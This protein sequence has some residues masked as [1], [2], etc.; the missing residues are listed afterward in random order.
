MRSRRWWLRVLGWVCGGCLTML[1]RELPLACGG[2]DPPDLGTRRQGVDWPCFLGMNHD[3]K[4]PERGIRTR[5]PAKGLPP[6]WVRRLGTS[7]GMPTISRGRLYSFERHGDQAELHCLQSETGAPLW[8]YAY[9]TEFEDPYGYDN[10]PR[11]SPTVDGEHV[12]LFGAEGML[13]CL[14]CVDG[15]L[16]WKLDTAREFGVVP[17]FFGVGSSPVVEGDLLLVPIGGSPAGSE[18]V[19]F[20]RLEGNGSGMVALD[21]RSGAV[22]YRLSDELASYASPR[23]TTIGGRRWC[24]AFLRGGLLAFDPTN[25]QI[26]FHFPWRAP[27][28]ESVNASNPVIVGTEV[29]ISETYG[30]GGALL[31]VRPGGYDVV[32]SDRERV[33][34][35]SL[36]THWNTPVEVDGMVYASSGRH[37]NNA[38]LRCVE[39]QT[40]KVRWS[41]PGL[42]RAS[43]LYVDGHF[44]CLC[45]YGELLLVRATPEKFTPVAMS[46]LEAAAEPGAD[47]G[48]GD[49]DGLGPRRLLGYPAWAAPILS[50]GLLYVRGKD[51]LVCLELIPA[52]GAEPAGASAV[53]GR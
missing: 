2:E 19:P 24:L 49:A 5:W 8:R 12:Y 43:L 50:H 20:D 21:K 28:L 41:E 45:E 6:V 1:G 32:W 36:Q 35:K 30:P 47:G 31:Q 29:L 7:Y 3:S 17:N 15:A 22:R 39:W 34:D 23:V 14:R 25:G 27:I 53:P 13:H 9:P 33:R 42:G 16:V 11:S 51:R 40:G 44:V 37:T 26:D 48:A 38:E 46:V 10:G 52:E 4:S 18:E